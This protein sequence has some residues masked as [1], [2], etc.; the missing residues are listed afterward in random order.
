[1]RGQAGPEWSLGK[2]SEVG[3]IHER[4]TFKAL[5]WLLERIRHVDDNLRSWQTIDTPENHLTCERCAPRAPELR[6]VQSNKKVVAIEDPV[7][8]GEYERRLKG[9]PS[10]FVTTLEAFRQWYWICESRDQ[11][12]FFASSSGNAPTHQGSYWSYNL[13]LAP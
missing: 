12:P 7:Q 10:P 11:H 5:A 2:W 3:K 6:W 8:A 9:R 13:E 1:M 4:V